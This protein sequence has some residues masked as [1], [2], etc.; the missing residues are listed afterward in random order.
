MPGF[1]FPRFEQQ[2]TED[3]RKRL[4]EVSRNRLPQQLK[5]RTMIKEGDAGH[6]IL[7]AATNEGVDLI[8]IATHGMTCLPHYLHGSVTQRVIQHTPCSVLV[9]RVATHKK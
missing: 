1:N 2:Q 6:E 8:V 7:Q 5:R 3:A 4:E 9:I